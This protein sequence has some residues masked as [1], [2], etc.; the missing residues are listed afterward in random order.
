MPD[1][2]YLEIG[3]FC[4]ASFCAAIDQNKVSATGIDNWSGFGGMAG[5]FYGNLSKF[6][7]E[8][9]IVSILERDFRT[10]DYKALGPFNI[11]FY[12]GSHE[13][14]DQYDGI[15]LP[16]VGLDDH[17]IVIVDDWNW[18]RVCRGTFAALSDVGRHI[19]YS[20]EVRT[21]LDGQGSTIPAAESEWHNGL[22]VAIVS[23]G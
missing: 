9:Q 7:G 2:R 15:R 17:A 20:I 23:R 19:E 18:D 12:D 22:F 6:C 4:G 5:Q 8:G 21:T 10:V 1:P 3:M 14:T 13:E 11:L 16:D